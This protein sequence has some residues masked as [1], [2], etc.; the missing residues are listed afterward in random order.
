MSKPIGRPVL[1]P[2]DND[3]TIQPQPST[4]GFVDLY[5]HLAEFLVKSRGDGQK[6]TTGTITLF[7]EQ[8]QFKLCLND[9]PLSRSTFISGGSLQQALAAADAALGSHRIK[10]RVR[11][12]VRAPD[13]QKYLSQ[14]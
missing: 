7:L 9:R 14:A 4:P 3:G 2:S 8:G 6:A 10:W 12:Y 11:G 5:P 13:R 1:R